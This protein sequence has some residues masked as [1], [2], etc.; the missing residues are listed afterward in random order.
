[1]EESAPGVFH[2]PSSRAAILVPHRT[3][4]VLSNAFEPYLPKRPGSHGAK[5]TA[6]FKTASHEEEEPN[7]VCFPLFIQLNPMDK[8]QLYYFGTYSQ[9]RYSDKLSYNEMVN[10]VSLKVKRF[11]AAQLSDKNRASWVTEELMKHYWP[12][13]EFP[14]E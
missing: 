11:W 5:L 7:H 10:Q 6:F 14:D 9:N 12:K 4:Y 13:P 8:N 2:T 1:G 3:Y